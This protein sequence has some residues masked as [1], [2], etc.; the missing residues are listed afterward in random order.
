MQDIS[1]GN[2]GWG[3]GVKVFVSECP[4]KTEEAEQHPCAAYRLVRLDPCFRA[5]ASRYHGSRKDSAFA[6]YPTNVDHAP[7]NVSPGAEWGQL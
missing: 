2:W 5:D 1:G 3:F 4:Y 6:I 7:Q